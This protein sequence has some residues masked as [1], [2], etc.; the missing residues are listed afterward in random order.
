[1]TLESLAPVLFGWPFMILA[2]LVMITGI[3][4]KKAAW[5]LVGALLSIPFSLYL[6]ATPRF[7][8]VG[9]I[10]PLFNLAAAYV[11]RRNRRWLAALLIV[12]FI[13]VALWLAGR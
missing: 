4:L 9:I 2:I 10:L 3:V 12:P 13:A 6:A 7:R 11:V 5:I 1:M 8:L